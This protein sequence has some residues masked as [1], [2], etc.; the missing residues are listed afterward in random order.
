MIQQ[1]KRS[2]FISLPHQKT[3]GEGK[4][5]VSPRVTFGCLQRRASVCILFI[6][7]SIRKLR[8]TTWIIRDLI[9]WR[10]YDFLLASHTV[11]HSCIPQT[12][13]ADV[14]PI[15]KLISLL[16]SGSI[17][18]GPGFPYHLIATRYAFPTLSSSCPI[19][20]IFVHRSRQPS[21][22]YQHTTCPPKIQ[23]L[24]I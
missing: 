14:H 17:A 1:S 22:E 6:I 23:L 18:H 20:K 2:L 8:R 5:R 24:Q 12:G 7:K 13:S 9:E 16:D 3:V 15:D 4:E 21:Y 11:G 10:A 19:S